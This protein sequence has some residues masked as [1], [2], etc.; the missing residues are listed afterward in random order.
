MKRFFLGLLLP[1]F[2][3]GMIISSLKWVILPWTST[4]ALRQLEKYTS[5]NSQV[6]VSAAKIKFMLLRPTIQIEDIE[7]RSHKSL[8]DVFDKI[9]LDRLSLHLD[10]FHI[11]TGRFQITAAILENPSMLLRLDPLLHSDS[12]PQELPLREIFQSLSTIPIQRIWVENMDLQLDWKIKDL[13]LHL[14]NAFM[15]ATLDDTRLAYKAELGRVEAYWREKPPFQFG[16]STQGIVTPDSLKV[17]NAQISLGKSLVNMSGSINNF[18]RVQL[19]PQGNLTTHLELELT[20]A[21]QFLRTYLPQIHAP[22]ISGNVNLTAKIHLQGNQNITGDMDLTTEQVRI[23]Q[24]DIGK[25]AIRGKYRNQ[26]IELEEVKAIHPAG[27]VTLTKTNLKL[28][29][30]WNYTSLLKIQKLDLQKLF[31]SLG[32]KGIPVD[33][34]IQGEGACEG[35]FENFSLLCQPEL[36]GSNLLVTQPHSSDAIVAISGF[37]ARGSLSV[38]LQKV[39]YKAKV[40]LGENQGQSDGVISFRDGFRIAFQSPNVDFKNIKNLVNLRFSGQSPVDGVT[41]GNS[42]SA[43]LR[44][45]LRPNNFTLEDYQLGNLESELTYETGHLKLSQINGLI[46]QSKYL[47]WLDINLSDSLLSGSF[48]FPQIDLKD[49]AFAFDRHF[50]FPLSVAGPGQGKMEF[51]G[52]FRFWDLSYSL[53]ASFHNGRVETETFSDLAAKIRSNHGHVVTD[54]LSMSKGGSQLRVH[55]RITPEKQ[56]DLEA[57]ALNFKLEESDFVTHMSNQIYGLFNASATLRGSILSPNLEASGTFTETVLQDQN[58]ANSTLTLS[59]DPTRTLLRTSLFGENIQTN[60]TIPRSGSAQPLRLQGRIN[61]WAYGTILALLGGGNLQPEYETL[62]TSEFDFQSPRGEWDQLTG[63]AAINQFQLKRGP[64]YLINNEPM[65]ISAEQGKFSM[66]RVAL[67][68]P[69]TQVQIRGADFD[70]NTLDLSLSANIELK[71]FQLFFPFFDDLGGALS[72]QTSVGGS[73]N[74][75][76]ILG[77]ARL[78]DDFFKFKGFPHPLEKIN[79][80]VTFSHSKILLPQIQGILAGGTVTGSGTLEMNGIRDLATQVK[81]TATGVNLNVPEKIATSGD[82][83]LTL[84]GQWFP[85]HLAGTYRVQTGLFEKEF[86]DSASGSLA[87]QQSPYLPQGLQ[88]RSFEPITLD[89]DIILEH[90]ILIK[91]SQLEG[92]VSGRLQVKGYPNSPIILGKVQTEKGAKV[93]FKDKIFEIQTG[94]VNFTNPVELNPDIFLSAR[95]RISE[96]DISL[97][98]QGPSKSLSPRL[99]SVPPLSENDLFS[100]LALGITSTR[101]EQ[102]VQSAEQAKQTATEVFGSVINQTVGKG[103]KSATGLSFQ[104]SNSYDNTK[105]ISV[106]KLTL[107]RQLGRKTSLQISRQLSNNSNTSDAKIQYQLSQT[108]SAIGSFEARAPQEDPTD[109]SLDK[110]QQS[111]FGLDL[112]FRREF[113]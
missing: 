83:D 24:F 9:S 60:V 113:K 45:R 54:E 6:T 29:S 68:G 92:M 72:L 101:L 2:I 13:S 69:G 5:K 77:S 16:F 78:K 99:S 50:H 107:S 26:E 84:N 15:T 76:K 39:A 17:L 74:H 42:H 103:F 22:H 31:I 21:D 100:L 61:K 25:A 64:L 112:E 37:S 90:N 49:I 59:V 73:W 70:F 44:M 51:S 98:V 52:P 4:W 89:L 95:S 1:I 36:V 104:V 3:L 23:D 46:D 79:T 91:N 63:R 27:E 47:G 30:P 110:D 33:L 86:T 34:N 14:K 87:V 109:K 97:I 88:E 102:N 28:R 10:I 7:I 56:I 57:Q 66:E 55:A 93:T 41:E 111:V 65:A 85:F 62:L 12:K 106:P 8:A 58:L 48:Q 19:E 35:Q 67:E 38:D 105:N 18:H 53:E 40:F 71:L 108:L 32:L 96:Y 80:E 75:P 20:E 81:L 94:L 43:T 82:L 11:L